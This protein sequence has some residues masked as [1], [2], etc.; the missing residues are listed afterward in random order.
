MEKDIEILRNYIKNTPSINNKKESTL[1]KSLSEK[2]RLQRI[3]QQEC[4]KKV[5]YA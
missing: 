5:I 4:L 2:K 3:V 1:Q